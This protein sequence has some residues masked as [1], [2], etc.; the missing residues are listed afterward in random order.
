VTDFANA[1]DRPYGQQPET[2]AAAVR[3]L[4]RLDATDLIPALGLDNWTPPVVDGRATCRTCGR[5]LPA[6][7][8]KACRSRLCAAGPDARG[9]K[10]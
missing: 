8:R 10:R 3:V 7:G 4:H 6:D 5:Q 2:R 1:V 9:V